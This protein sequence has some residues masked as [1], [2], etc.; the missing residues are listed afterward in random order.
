MGDGMEQE[1]MR[2]FEQICLDRLKEIGRVSARKWAESM[3]YQNPNALTKVIRRILETMPDKI[4]V[5]N[6]H[7]PREYESV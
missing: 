3:G 5:Y 6:N 1:E 7:K 2:T 4:V